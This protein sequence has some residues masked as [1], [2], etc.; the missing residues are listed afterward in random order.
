MTVSISDFGQKRH[1]TMQKTFYF[2]FLSKWKKPPIIIY[3]LYS[4][5]Y[6]SI[7]WSNQNAFKYHLGIMKRGHDSIE[8]IAAI[9]WLF[10]GLF[11]LPIKRQFSCSECFSPVGKPVIDE[12]VILAINIRTSEDGSIR[13]LWPNCQ[14]SLIFSSQ[15]LRSLCK[16]KFKYKKIF[17]I[18]FVNKFVV[19]LHREQLFD[20]GT[21]MGPRP[22]IGR[23]FIQKR[24]LS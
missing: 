20:L 6:H 11:S 13:K 7:I 24:S 4:R 23:F 18:F 9:N 8:K 19:S 5:K 14:F 1:K 21:I 3:S 22:L 10:Y 12:V 16:E 15:P 17:K 2:D